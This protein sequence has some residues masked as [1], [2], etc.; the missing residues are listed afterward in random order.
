MIARKLEDASLGVFCAPDYA[1][2]RP[3][4]TTLAM[5]PQHDLIQFIT[6]STGRPFP[7]QF[8]D[9]QGTLS[10]FRSRADSGCWTTMC[11]RAWAGRWLGAVCSRS[12]ISWHRGAV[13][14]FKLIR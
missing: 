10:T 1:A 2:R 7:W 12:T 11:W 3:A 13:A 5:L 14:R 9:E 4:P 6:P 8:V